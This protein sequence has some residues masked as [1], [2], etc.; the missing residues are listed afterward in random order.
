MIFFVSLNQCVSHLLL[1]ISWVVVIKA[2]ADQSILGLRQ[3][4]GVA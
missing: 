2:R 1:G 3:Q 4:L